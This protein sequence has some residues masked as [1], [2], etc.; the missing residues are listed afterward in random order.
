MLQQ[1]GRAPKLLRHETKVVSTTSL[2]GASKE[3]G[4]ERERVKKLILLYLL[5]YSD[6]PL[7]TSSPVGEEVSIGEKKMKSKINK[8]RQI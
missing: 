3:E 4:R 8:Y 5:T 1:T 6:V 2:G 7:L